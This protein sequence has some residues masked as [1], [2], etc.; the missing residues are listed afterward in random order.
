MPTKPK[1]PEGIEPSGWRWVRVSDDLLEQLR[2]YGDPVRV[3]VE[4]G[5]EPDEVII[6]FQKVEEGT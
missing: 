6:T 5:T 2:E 4:D 1:K 3:K